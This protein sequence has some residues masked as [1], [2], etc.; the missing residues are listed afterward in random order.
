MAANVQQYPYI[1]IFQNSSYTPIGIED[2]NGRKIVKYI[3]DD[4]SEASTNLAAQ[5]INNLLN[6]HPNLCATFPIQSINDFK[7]QIQQKKYLTINNDAVCLSNE[8]EAPPG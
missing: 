6:N 2:Y 4:N 7:L 8:R 3:L 5:T 1:G